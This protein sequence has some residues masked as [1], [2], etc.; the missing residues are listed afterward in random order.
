PIVTDDTRMTA[1]VARSICRKR[2]VV[3]EDIS[4][5][6]VDYYS[7]GP[8]DIGR[9]TRL[10]L[11]MLASGEP[12]HTAGVRAC[13]LLGPSGDGNGAIMTAAPA[14]LFSFNDRGLLVQTCA[15]VAR[16]THGS[17]TCVDA[18]VAFGTTIALLIAEEPRDALTQAIALSSG[19]EPRVVEA[20]EEGM[21]GRFPRERMP[22]VLDT[23]QTAVA[24][25]SSS[26]TF[27]EAVL[28]AVNRGGDT[29]TAGSVT[30]ALAGAAWGRTT[31]P[32]AWVE[33]LERG[34]EVGR[35]VGHLATCIHDLVVGRPAV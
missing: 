27:E 28:R 11:D 21:S 18:A 16:I 2:R 35:E 33:T 10:A 17:R 4:R 5:E 19:L 9:T 1:A 8:T 23:L 12:W 14:A 22:M 34:P 6:F 26:E 20:L 25:L 31:I 15:D 13:A 29:D 7:T 30:G 24:C 32:P 3:P